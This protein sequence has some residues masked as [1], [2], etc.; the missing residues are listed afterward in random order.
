MGIV[1]VP[2]PARAADAAIS[3]AVLLKRIEAVMAADER[4]QQGRAGSDLGRGAVVRHF[5]DRAVAGSKRPQVSLSIEAGAEEAMVS[6][7]PDDQADDAGP[8]RIADVV[9]RIDAFRREHDG[10][11]TAGPKHA[12]VAPQRFRFETDGSGTIRWVEGVD[13]EPLIGLSLRQDLAQDGASRGDGAIPLRTR[14]PFHDVRMTIDGDGDLSGDWLISAFPAFDRATGRFTGY[15]GAARRPR[16]DESAEPM[17][18]PAGM[19]MD[20]L[21]QLV[22]ELRTPANAIAGFAEMIE[23]QMLGAV[24]QSY[25]HRAAAI[26][27]EARELIGAIDDLDLAARID[28]GVLSL[29]PAPV[30]L[31][32]LLKAVVDDL[33]PLSLQRGSAIRIE[34]EDAAVSCDRRALERLIA[35]LMATLVSAS[36][37]GER[38]GVRIAPADRSNLVLTI[39]RPAALRHDRGDALRDLDEHGDTALLGTGFALRL[40]HDLARE[41]GGS[42]AFGPAGIILSLPAARGSG[43][44]AGGPGRT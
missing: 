36:G 40:G 24:A 27:A 26:R 2:Q 32:P 35:R 25:R 33:A 34:G 28:G 1:D 3:L 31:R 10:L 21:R 42:L 6:A 39:D 15:R 22:H 38:I 30:R 37:H 5:D 14:A 12:S 43:N 17:R 41:L 18:D 29:V 4:R 8:F 19:H 16:R 13:R 7:D 44:D 23:T 20:S 9:A 11:T